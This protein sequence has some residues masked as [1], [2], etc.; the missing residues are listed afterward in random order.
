MADP[1]LSVL[2]QQL[3]RVSRR[4]FLQSLVDALLWC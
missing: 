1:S 3:A 4:L 2:Y